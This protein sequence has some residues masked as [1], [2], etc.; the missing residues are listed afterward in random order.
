MLLLGSNSPQSDVLT[1]CSTSDCGLLV[2]KSIIGLVVSV[3]QHCVSTSDCGLLVPESIIGL[4]VSVCQ[5]CV[6]TS[7]CGLLVPESIHSV[8]KH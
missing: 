8:G 7:D 3:Y 2:P 4:V 5:H 1:Q 6:S